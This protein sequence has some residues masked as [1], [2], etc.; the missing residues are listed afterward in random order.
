MHNT[1]FCIIDMQ[2]EFED[3]A[4]AC[5]DQVIREVRIA[6]KQRSGIIVLEYLDSG[7]TFAEIKNA[8]GD[9]ELV[10]YATK[11]EDAGGVVLMLAALKRD[12]P[13]DI[14]RFSGVNRVACV[15]NTIV[16][17]QDFKKLWNE[18]AGVEIAIN[19]T[20]CECPKEGLEVLSTRGDFVN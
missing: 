13:T 1:T 8:I 15:D 9:Y 16:Q 7:D 10:T 20:W 19:A 3:T 11:D 17:Y 6:K 5:L 14:V 18:P 12:F 2:D 4:R